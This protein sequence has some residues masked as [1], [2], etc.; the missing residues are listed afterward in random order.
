M[1]FL[2]Q[3]TPVTKK[4]GPLV[5]S[6]DGN[7]LA[8]GIADLSSILSISKNDGSFASRNSTG[9]IEYAGRGCYN[10][11]FD[12]TDLNTIGCFLVSVSDSGLMQ[13]WNDYFVLSQ[14][15][16]DAVTGSGNFAI[17]ESSLANTIQGVLST[18][19]GSGNWTTADT[20][21]LSTKNDVLS[22]SGAL[23]SSI[24]NINGYDSS[25]V[26]ELLTR[27][28]YDRASYLDN[29][30]D[31]SLFKADTSELAKT[32]EINSI[33]GMIEIT[34]SSVNYLL[35]NEHGNGNWTTANI[36]ELSTKNDI[37]STSGALQS[38]IDNISGYD[39]SGVNELLTRL[40]SN[41]ASY[42]D[43]LNDLSLFKADVSQLATLSALYS[44]SGTV[45][46]I[47]SNVDELLTINHGSGE[48]SSSESDF[49]ES[50]SLIQ[51]GINDLPSEID[52][53]L[54]TNHGSG[55]W[56]T[57]DSGLTISETLSA[58]QTS[59]DEINTYITSGGSSSTLIYGTSITIMVRG[60][61]N[62]LVE[63]YNYT[64]ERLTE[65]ISIG[66]SLVIREVASSQYVVDPDTNTITPTPSEP[67]LS[68]IALK[69]ACLITQGEYKEASKRAVSIK[70][71]PSSIDT[72][73]IANQLGKL[74]K[75]MCD[76]YDKAK[77][78]YQAGDGS[79]G[80]AI[81]G[82]YSNGQYYNRNKTYFN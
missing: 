40:T 58:I 55:T 42:L 56:A 70:D 68:L 37:L 47:P 15:V 67:I 57:T 51:S 65:L 9:V 25:G 59:I 1:S 16:Y 49:S 27:L 33:S 44:V 19:H 45:N 61:I 22:T 30:N 4:I 41:R 10:V 8:S 80:K 31:P 76:S 7:T 12:D 26:N 21:N 54:S 46:S 28:T 39:S 64:D 20:A 52:V 29:L 2:R 43:N 78:R 75:A 69:T 77:L 71:G 48:W 18:N 34:P 36:S 24:D 81:T 3:N 60:L 14:S 63:P 79:V 11:P 6:S 66:A 62:D 50:I 73:E 5:L 72:K 82:P 74:S 13:Y 38:S 32:S 53:L 23:Q 35:T 17:D